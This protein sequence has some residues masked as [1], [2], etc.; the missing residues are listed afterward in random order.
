MGLPSFVVDR[1]HR[2]L[3]KRTT[4]SDPVLVRNVFD[5]YTQ[6]E[7]R[8]SHALATC[9]HEDRQFLEAFLEWSGASPPK[10]ASAVK[11]VEQRIPMALSQEDD[12][13]RGLPD[14]WLYDEDHW[15]LLVESKLNST[16]AQD[17]LDR[18]V[19]TARRAGFTSLDLL[20]LTVG[21]SAVEAAIRPNSKRWTDL[22]AFAV[23]HQ[24]SW[25]S[26]LVE[27]MEI[28]ESRWTEEG[29]MKGTITS[30]EGIRF[31]KEHP[32]NYFQA[33]RLL[34]LLVAE[35]RART[36]LLALGMNPSGSGRPGITDSGISVWDYIPLQGL[37]DEHFTSYPHLTVGLHLNHVNATITTPNGVR[38]EVWNH[39]VDLG[40]RG[41]GEV[42]SKLAHNLNREL[43]A[44]AGARP[45]LSLLQRH[46]PSQRAVPVVDATLDFDLRTIAGDEQV[47]VKFQ[48][49]WAKAAFEA[50]A[51]R[52]SN[53]QLAV[54]AQLPYKAEPVRE[55]TVVDLIARTWIACQPWLVDALG[56]RAIQ[57]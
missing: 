27:Y 32:Y 20:T 7:N 37:G 46:Y 6:P 34:N 43:A 8:L 2:S 53:L 52:S 49:G 39:L 24:G 36:D 54:G 51:S 14:I 1:I 13:P 56:L 40:P 31:D 26:R 19:R 23:N 18:H 33:K 15:C 12:S 10:N 38:R 45:T 4:C 29:I 48:D 22:Y 47:G 16:L 9:L 21:G 35:L 30:F 11:V 3:R 44:V 17:Q 50:L 57:A 25:P 41:F 28:A 5:Q 55:K 42:L